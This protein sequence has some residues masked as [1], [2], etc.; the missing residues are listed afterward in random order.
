[1]HILVTGAPGFMAALT[2]D[3]LLASGHRVTGL[4]NLND[5]YDIRLKEWRLWQ[6]AGRAG[7][8]FMQADI[9]RPAELSAIW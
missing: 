5:A 2:I 9:T 8:E 1:M 7:F 3:L 4:Y 6:L